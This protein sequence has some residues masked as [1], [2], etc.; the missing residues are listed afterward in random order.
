MSCFKDKVDFNLHAKYNQ[1]T[2]KVWTLSNA[3]ICKLNLLAEDVTLSPCENIPYTTVFPK[4]VNLTSS[5]LV[6]IEAFQR[7]PFITD[8]DT[9]YL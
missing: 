3:V 1:D 5:L 6:N 8:H 4:L 7:S 9:C 2:Q